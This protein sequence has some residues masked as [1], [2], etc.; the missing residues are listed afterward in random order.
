MSIN[1]WLSADNSVFIVVRSSPQAVCIDVC[2]CSCVSVDVRVAAEVRSPGG[3]RMSIGLCVSLDV[4]V[5]QWP[6]F[7]ST[8]QFLLLLDASLPGENLFARKEDGSLEH[9]VS[10]SVHSLFY[11][12]RVEGFVLPVCMYIIRIAPVVGQF[13]DLQGSLC[14]QLAVGLAVLVGPCLCCT[15]RD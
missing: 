8:H 6:L 13:C 4:A 3:V 15:I 7:V 2:I 1:V 10:C 11:V 14:F 5:H 9:D 12:S